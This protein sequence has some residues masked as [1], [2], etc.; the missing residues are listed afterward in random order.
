MTTIAW[1]LNKWGEIGEHVR[2][3]EMRNA[4]IISVERPEMKRLLW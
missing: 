4:Q 3:D 1:G 2:Q